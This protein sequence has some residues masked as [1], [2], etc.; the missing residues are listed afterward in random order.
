MR[1][2]QC[3]RFLIGT[4]IPFDKWPSIIEKYLQE[5]NLYHHSFHYCMETYDNSERCRSVLDCTKC[6]T[7]L[8]PE[9]AC[10]RCRKEAENT[11]RKGTGC[12]RALKENPFLGSL[13]IRRTQYNTIQSLNNFNEESNT[14]KENI[15]AIISKIYKRYGFAETSLIYRD[16]NFFSRHVSTPTPESEYLINGYEGSGITLYRSCLSQDNGIILVVE[17]RYPG[18]VSDA[19]PYADTMGKLFP[20]VKRLSATK[21]IMDE[22][23]QIRYEALHIQAKPLIC[24]AKDFF[25]DHMPEEKGNDEPDTKVSVASWLKKLSKSYGYTYLGYSNYAYLMEKKLPNGHYICLEFVSNPLSPDAD[26]YVRLCGLGFNHTIWKDEFSPQNP[27]DAF[28]YF[29]K[30][31]N[32]L[33]EAAQTVF[34]AILDL[35]PNTP[36]WFIPTH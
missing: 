15:Y 3:Y 5:Q 18:E 7:C 31:F 13:N 21:I 35:Y 22:D 34:P 28:E 27:R 8:A 33:A 2:L 26:P 4:K 6:D 14:S 30:L 36:D 16:I 24:Q 17:S 25:N 23:E 19:T 32:T 10:E 12:E 20:G 9:S 11:L 29:T 1:I